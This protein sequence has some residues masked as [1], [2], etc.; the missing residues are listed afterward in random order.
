VIRRLLCTLAGHRVDLVTWYLAT[1]RAMPMTHTEILR[2]CTR[3]HVYLA[4]ADA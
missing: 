1:S 2:R 3:C 4:A